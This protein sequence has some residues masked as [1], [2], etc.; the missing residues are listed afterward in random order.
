MN[1]LSGTLFPG[2]S[3]STDS[4]ENSYWVR[5]K[6]SGYNLFR[7]LINTKHVPHCVRAPVKMHYVGVRMHACPFLCMPVP[8]LS[9]RP[10]LTLCAKDRHA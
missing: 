10:T 2:L 8:V 9:V 3:E 1:S 7:L 5:Y 4:L 6:K